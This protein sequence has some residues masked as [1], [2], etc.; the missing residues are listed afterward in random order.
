MRG[1]RPRSEY[2]VPTYRNTLESDRPRQQQQ[3]QQV[4]IPEEPPAPP[5][6]APTSAFDEPRVDLRSM[7]QQSTMIMDWSE[8]VERFNNPPPLVSEQQ[9]TAAVD[10]SQPVP[11]ADPVVAP[12][13]HQPPVALVPPLRRGNNWSPNQ[14]AKAD[15][16][17][18]PPTPCTDGELKAYVDAVIGPRIRTRNGQIDE[19]LFNVER[20]QADENAVKALMKVL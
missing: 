8:E 18:C 15:P 17:V 19:A 5:T 7:L 16:T 20:S 1:N 13:R 9:P 2:Y 10:A 3:R 12:V 11:S 4:Q 6:A 14:A